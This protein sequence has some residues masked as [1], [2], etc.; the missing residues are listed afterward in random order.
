[1]AGELAPMNPIDHVRRWLPDLTVW[2]RD[3]HAHPE[4]GFEEH[5]TS[6]LVAE[7]LASWGIEVHRGIGGTG[8]V[9]V[10]RNGGG[11][12]A[13]GLRAD[14]DALPIKEENGF[15]HRSTV[16]GKMHACGHDGHT[17]MLLAAARYLAE[18]RRFEGTVHLIFQPAEEGLGGGKAMLSDGL[19]DRFPCNVLYALHNLPRI[20][21]GRYGIRPGPMMA[22]AAFFDIHV[23]GR[24]GHGAMPETTVDPVVCG[25]QLVS[26]LQ[27]VVARNV[28]PSDTAVLSVTGFGAGGA[29]NVIPGRVSLC[30]TTRA[31]RT[32]TLRLMEERARVLAGGIA[33]GFGATAEVEFRE[34][35][36]PLVNS[37]AETAA[38]ADAA[39]SLVG[40]ENVD[41][42]F[43]AIMAS[44]DFSYMLAA[45]P[46][47]FLWVGNNDGEAGGCE[48]H[49]PGYDFN[50][51]A[52]PY[53][54]GVLAA[55][56]ERELS[57]GHGRTSGGVT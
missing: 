32:E 18:T 3:F 24:G 16:P 13:V 50:D 29:Y 26:A 44:E 8:V 53:C 37:P 27:S 48:V 47:A 2:R 46:G 22:G 49:N 56:A 36:L 51:A 42:E 20:P 21:V 41:R 7:R 10:L 9:G 6:A 25:A 33:A 34:I 19:F 17:T 30:G 28:A 14:M 54:A 45:R 11:N 23:N 39:A 12:R 55:V 31:F 1:V 5:R 35:F 15:A 4:I 57:R 40:E 38:I 52:I 43:P